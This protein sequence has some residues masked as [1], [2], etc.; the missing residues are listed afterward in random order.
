MQVLIAPTEDIV[1]S[2]KTNFSADEAAAQTILSVYNTDNFVVND[3][4]VLDELGSEIAELRKISS[5]DATARTITVTVATNQLHLKDASI[6]RIRYNQ[7]KFYRSSTKTGTYSH[8]SS[9]GSP[10]DIHVDKPEGTEF[11]DSSGTSTSWYKATY[12]NATSGTESSIDDAEASKASD[13]EHYTSIYKIKV[14]AG[15]QNNSY[16]G[17]DLVDRYRIEAE[18]ETEGAIIG[19][20]DLPFSSTPKILQHII[21]LLAAGNLLAKEYG[22]ESDV[23]VS[24]TGQRKIDRAEGL[25][26]KIR[27]GKIRLVGED[28]S[29]IT[30]KSGVMASCSN[31]FDED[32]YNKG[33][34]FTLEDENFKSADPSDGIGSTKRIVSKTN[35]F[36]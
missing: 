35:G 23:E 18:A 14:E 31:V 15:F 7:R 10:V 20:Y 17:S 13:A 3:Y 12:Y 30:E 9:E 1:L 5:V 24:K 28:G 26:D 36:K 4:I 19:L 27:D 22:L 33:E 16:I 2:E 29:E 8:L 34:I 21:T 6:T 25:L 32:I 11:E